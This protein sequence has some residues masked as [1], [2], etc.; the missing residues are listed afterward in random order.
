MIPSPSAAAGTGA[1]GDSADPNMTREFDRIAT[2]SVDAGLNVGASLADRH[3]A[4]EVETI[5]SASLCA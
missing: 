1:R 4:A 5:P 2:G 3:R